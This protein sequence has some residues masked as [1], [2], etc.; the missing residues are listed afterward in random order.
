MIRFKD[1]YKRIVQLQHR[2]NQVMKKVVR[3]KVLKVFGVG[4]IYAISSSSWVNPI[5][6]VPKKGGITVVKNDNNELISTRTTRGWRVCMDYKKLN[7]KTRKDHFPLP[8]L[9]QM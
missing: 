4:M 6:V 2:L 3:N 1:N 8:F 5:R 9:D 7:K